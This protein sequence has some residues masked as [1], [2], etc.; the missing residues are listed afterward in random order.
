[1]K[2]ILALYLM[3]AIVAGS[4]SAQEFDTNEKQLAEIYSGEYTGETYSPYAER[5]FASQPLFGDTHV[6]TALSMD[7]GGFGNRLGVR[8]AYRDGFQIHRH[9]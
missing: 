6:H 9:P 3:L 5:N 1:M 8:E 7:A 2:R 4:A